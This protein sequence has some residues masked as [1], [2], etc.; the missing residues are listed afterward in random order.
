MFFPVESEDRTLR[1]QL[2]LCQDHARLV[3]EVFRKVLVMIDCLI[4]GDFNELGAGLEEVEKLHLD[5]REIRRV[6]M[7]ELHSTGGML[8]DQEVLYRLIGKSGEVIDLIEGIGV[9]LWEMGERQWRIPEKVGEGLANMAE[10]ALET[11][12]KLRASLMSLGFD[13]DKVMVLARGVD[14]GERKVDA[15]YRALDLEI[16]TSESGFPLILILRD[17][18]ERIEDMTDRAYEEADIIRILAR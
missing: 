7:K 14:E 4:K 1:N 2:M 13:S 9:R 10:A 15:M 3:V 18:V 16:I 8:V 17:I 5:S 6:M 11:L 12:M